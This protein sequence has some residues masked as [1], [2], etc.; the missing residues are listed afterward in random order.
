MTI[1]ANR[2]ILSTVGVLSLMSTLSTLSHAAPF[3]VAVSPS[4][5]ELD[6]KNSARVGQTLQLQNLGKQTANL[7]IRT[8]DWTFSDKGDINYYEALVAN[9]CRPWVTLER[10]SIAL[11]AQTKRSI[12]F[13]IDVPPKAPMT[14]CRF[15]IAI[16]GA[17]PTHNTTLEAN[18]ANLSIP[19]SG[20]IAVAVYVA[21]NGAQPQLTLQKLAITNINGQRTPIIIVQNKG[22]AHGRLEGSLNATD[23]A[24]Q[25]Y[26]LVVENTPILPNQTRQLPLTPKMVNGKTA[27]PKFPVKGKGQLDWAK[28]S[29]KLNAEFK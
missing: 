29:F 28:G 5:F 17:D 1:R 18:G 10:N 21:L 7:K 12:R 4:R 22:G 9:S 25:A 8:L 16:E 14:E 24:R 27:A 3:E 19:V 20:R 6:A 13:Q 26:E 2:F 23:S 15:M 11:P